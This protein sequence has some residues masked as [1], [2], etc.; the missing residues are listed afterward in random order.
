MIEIKPGDNAGGT[1][2]IGWIRICS[3][4]PSWQERL[5]TC[6]RLWFYRLRGSDTIA[7]WS[8]G[9]DKET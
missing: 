9:A 3:K 6:L 2:E 1:L 4:P 8:I 5:L 7:A